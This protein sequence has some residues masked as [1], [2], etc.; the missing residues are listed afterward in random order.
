MVENQCTV[1][2][3]YLG[4]ALWDGGILTFLENCNIF[5]PK[6]PFKCSHLGR[7][8]RALSEMQSPNPDCLLKMFCFFWGEGLADTHKTGFCL[9]FYFF[10]INTMGFYGRAHIS[11]IFFH[12]LALW[13]KN[14]EEKKRLMYF[15]QNILPELMIHSEFKFSPGT[16]AGPIFFVLQ[17]TDSQWNFHF[18][19]AGKESQWE[20]LPS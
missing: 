7:S 13:T 10:I 6:E 12:L 17:Q 1:K 14:R 16:I 9:R 4:T 19:F 11:L 2:K 20:M 3:T 8:Q 18:E 15:Q 5:F